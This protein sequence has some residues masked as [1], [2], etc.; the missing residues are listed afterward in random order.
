MNRTRIS[1][2]KPDIVRYFDQLPEKVF[3]QKDIAQFLAEQRKFWRLAQST[4]TQEFIRY[5]INSAKLSKIV[6]P[7][8]QPYKKETRFAWGDASLYE[9]M[10]MLRPGCYFSHYTAMAFHGLTEQLPK[11]TYL[12]SE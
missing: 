5:L 8:P 12:N 7:F 10:L 6:F 1:I 4:T 2:A 11:T 3:R 9:I